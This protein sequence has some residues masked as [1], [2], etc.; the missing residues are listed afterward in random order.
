MASPR[1]ESP[2]PSTNS[3]TGTVDFGFQE[4]PLDA[5]AARVRG[6]FSSVARSYDRMNDAMSLGVH[7]VWKSQAITALNPQ[8]GE[9]LLDV[10]GGTGDMA[11]RWCRAGSRVR[12][13]R[14]GDPARAVVCDINADMVLA[15]VDPRKDY[16]LALHRTVGD[17]EALP[18][19]DATFDALTIAFGIRNVSRREV[20]LSEFHRVLKPGGRL[21]VL[22][23]AVPPGRALR[24]VYDLYSFGVIPR[25]GSALAGDSESYQYL[26]ESI[27]RFPVPAQFAAMVEAAGFAR[28]RWEAY[29]GG[30]CNLHVGW[31]MT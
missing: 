21:G 16:G 28:V 29:S 2:A 11:R 10:A 18:F 26:V 8:P 23:F 1:T 7:R 5:K 12:A 27:R 30:I 20:A 4:V 19:A 13:R 17:A 6:V 15:G 14:G 25:L 24:S 3:N 9:V 22:E 31:K